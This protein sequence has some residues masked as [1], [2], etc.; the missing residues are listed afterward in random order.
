MQTQ[1]D[2]IEVKLDRALETAH[3]NEIDLAWVKTALKISI[4]GIISLAVSFI[5]TIWS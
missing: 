4:V 5:K 1:L 3:K 2:R